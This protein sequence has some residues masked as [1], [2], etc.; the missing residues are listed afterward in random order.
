MMIAHQPLQNEGWGGKG[1][2]LPPLWS[3]PADW[4]SEAEPLKPQGVLEMRR[5]SP[6]RSPERE[7]GEEDDS[8][9]SISLSVSEVQTAVSHGVMLGDLVRGERA[10]RYDGSYRLSR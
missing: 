10:S 8:P 1:W 4:V 3:T 6:G 2:R 5:R 9:H 7:E